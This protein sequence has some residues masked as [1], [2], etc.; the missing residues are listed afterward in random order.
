MNSVRDSSNVGNHFEIARNIQKLLQP[1]LPEHHRWSPPSTDYTNHSLTCQICN[2]SVNGVER[3]LVCNTCEKG[4]H[5]SCLQ[6]HKQG[7]G[8]W[9]CSQCS[10][11]RNGKCLPPKYGSDRKNVTARS[12]TPLNASSNAA[13]GQGSMEKLGNSGQKVNNQKTTASLEPRSLHPAHLV[14]NN[15]MEKSAMSFIRLLIKQ[16]KN[17]MLHQKIDGKNQMLEEKEKRCLQ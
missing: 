2:V 7:V 12:Q 13:G 5:I 16:Q 9:S 11:A 8:D 1:R 15:E 6:L 10:V 4:N 17:D 14:Y 3:L